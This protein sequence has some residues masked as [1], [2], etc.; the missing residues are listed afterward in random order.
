MGESF[1]EKRSE[2][3]GQG[4]EKRS[5]ALGELDVGDAIHDLLEGGEALAA[6][7]DLGIAGGGPDAG[8]ELEDALVVDA[9]VVAVDRDAALHAVLEVVATEDVMAGDQPLA[10]RAA[11]L[12]GA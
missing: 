7:D 12:F 6:G 11:E 2:V 9:A 10:L 3:R 4:S 5:G 1:L 8:A